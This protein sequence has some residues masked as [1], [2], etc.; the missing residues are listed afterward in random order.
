M[1][2][3]QALVAE[4]WGLISMDH[5]RGMLVRSR[6]VSSVLVVEDEEPVRQLRRKVRGL[7]DAGG[8]G[9]VEVDVGS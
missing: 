1:T 4:R 5:G 7:L 3:R 2:V 6:A 8:S 9:E